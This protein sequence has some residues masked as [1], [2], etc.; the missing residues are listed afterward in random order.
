MKLR[1]IMYFKLKLIS[2]DSNIDNGTGNA[3]NVN[4]DNE[5]SNKVRTENSSIHGNLYFYLKLLN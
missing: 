5:K 2:S 3:S 1:N 4:S